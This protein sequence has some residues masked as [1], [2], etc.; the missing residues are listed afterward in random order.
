MIATGFGQ[1]FGGILGGWLVGFL[2]NCCAQR[3][4]RNLRCGYV[5]IGE[6]RRTWIRA[7]V[8]FL[9][10]LIRARQM[11]ANQGVLQSFLN[12]NK[13]NVCDS[14]MI[15]SS[16]FLGPGYRDNV[17][18]ER[19][20]DDIPIHHGREVG[21]LEERPAGVQ[22]GAVGVRRRSPPNQQQQQE[23]LQDHDDEPIVEAG[24]GERLPGPAEDDSGSSS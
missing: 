20:V 23:G 16:L 2:Y 11:E 3:R 5:G 24:L 18:D 1:L 17:A 13:V 9:R 14:L 19:A 15:L 22:A 7:F 10:T 8:I 12:K 21:R 4:D 6:G